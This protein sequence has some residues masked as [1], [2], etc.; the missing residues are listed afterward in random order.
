MG[1][2]GDRERCLEERLQAVRAQALTGPLWDHRICVHFGGGGLR[3]NNV[4]F[5]SFGFCFCLCAYRGVIDDD[6]AAAH[7]AMENVFFEMLDKSPLERER[8]RSC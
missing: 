2:S 6:I 5:R 7:V 4:L 8:E 3:S 1:S